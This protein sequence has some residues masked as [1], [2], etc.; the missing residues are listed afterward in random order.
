MHQKP[1]STSDNPRPHL[2]CPDFPETG[3]LGGPVD[4][5][6]T[7]V[8]QKQLV[9]CLMD[10]FIGHGG[11]PFDLAAGQGA[12]K[13]TELD[14]LAMVLEQFEQLGPALVVGD[15]VGAEINAAVVRYRTTGHGR[16]GMSP[17]S[18]R[19]RRRAWMRRMVRQEQR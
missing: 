3:K 17:R 9:L 19:T 1:A 13:Y 4:V 15:V 16:W 18:R 7:E 6:R 11:E 8:Y 2:R 12:E 10:D 5:V 14:V